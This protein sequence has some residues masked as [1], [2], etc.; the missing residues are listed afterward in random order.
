[1]TYWYP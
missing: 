1:V